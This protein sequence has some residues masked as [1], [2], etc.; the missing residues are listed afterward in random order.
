[1]NL[2]ISHWRALEPESKIT[3]GNRNEVWR[4]SLGGE[5]V[6][7]RR[8]RRDEPSLDW[9][10]DLIEH[11]ASLGFEVPTVRRSTD[12]RRHVNG[13]VVQRWLHGRPPD[14]TRDWQLVA[15]TLRRVHRLTSNYPQRPGC[16]AVAK[17]DRASSSIDAD[18]SA[19]PDDVASDVLSVFASVAAMPVS[20]IHGDPMAGNI[21]IVDNDVGLLDFDESRVDVAWHDLSNLGVQVLDEVEHSQA[22]QL[23]DAW[24]AANGWVLEP[25]YAI[26][27]LE[28]LRRSLTS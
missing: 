13:I 22:T 25:E 27:R 11:L 21:R 19:L 26:S 24:E 14:S 16:C 5:P 10:L 9:E 6:S 15:D 2:D 28:A 1:M 18:M 23:S 3:E 17:L 12:G 8:S 4:G 7:I 20:V